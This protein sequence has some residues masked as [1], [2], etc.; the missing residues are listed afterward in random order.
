MCDLRGA[1]RQFRKDCSGSKRFI[2]MSATMEGFKD[3][4][5]LSD[6]DDEDTDVTH[7]IL[8]TH[9]ETGRKSL[10]VGEDIVSHI[11]G[12]EKAESGYWRG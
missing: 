5:P 8:R 3:R 9:P 4:A 10:Y 11:I 6:A 7:P 1:R 2:P 12:L